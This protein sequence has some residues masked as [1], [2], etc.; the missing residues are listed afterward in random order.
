M[1][2]PLSLF[3]AHSRTCARVL[4]CASEHGVEALTLQGRP[5]FSLALPSGGLYFDVNGDGTVDHL[6]VVGR[7]PSGA[8]ALAL[9]SA[10]RSLAADK[11]KRRAAKQ[12]AGGGGGGDDDDDDEGS[13]G[14]QGVGR[15]HG[16]G[17]HLSGL[18]R[19]ALVGASG[20]ASGSERASL[21]RRHG[22]LPP[23]SCLALS[24]VPAREQLFNGSLCDGAGSFRDFLTHPEKGVNDRARNRGKRGVSVSPLVL[25]LVRLTHPPFLFFHL[26]VDRCAVVTMFPDFNG[27]SKGHK[28]EVR[29]ALPCVVP[30]PH[31]GVHFEQARLVKGARLLAQVGLSAT[32]ANRQHTQLSLALDLALV[33][34][35]L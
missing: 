3:H 33:V 16:L 29:G 19:H 12:A 18:A 20:G 2:P 15:H 9:A 32:C 34:S 30:R 4:G 21:A 26:Y 31:G 11:A 25:D 23:C 24:G 35:C 17:D 5:V 1:L 13:G 10:A 14:G 22:D 7:R 6:S 27:P 28:V 8:S